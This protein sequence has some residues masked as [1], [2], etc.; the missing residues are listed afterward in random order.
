MRKISSV[1]L[2]LLWVIPAMAQQSLDKVLREVEKNNLAYKA[3]RS[4]VNAQKAGNHVGNTP[5]NP[6]VDGG[7]LWGSPSAIGN[8]KDISVNQEIDFP[9]VY[10]HQNKLADLRDFQADVNAGQYRLALNQE[11]AQLWVELV[12]LNQ[13]IAIQ[14]ERAALAKKLDNAYAERLIAGEANLIDRNKAA[15]NFIQSKK[16][17][18]RLQQEKELLQLSL[19]A[20]NGNQPLPVGQVNYEQINLPPDFELWAQGVMQ[21]NPQARWYTLEAEAADRAVKLNRSKSLPKINGGYMMENTVGEKFQGVTLGLSIPL[22]ENRNQVKAARLRQESNQLEEQDFQS[23][24]KTELLK[25]YRSVQLA[26]ARVDGFRKEL[27]T[28]QQRDLLQ[29]ALD[30]G[31]I[32]LIEY[33]LE[34]QFNYEAIDQLVEA[35]KELQLA[36]VKM[37]VLGEGH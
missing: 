6:Y 19:D 20:L 16:D 22:W 31:Q 12:N 1:L 26:S 23:Q 10:H 24:L 36:W 3:Q 5:N 9:T 14:Q 29:E 2:M 34:M 37:K 11:A 8:R 27:E 7:Y 13:R 35:E 4:S 30:A 32:S 18:A 25:L 17:L 28:V 21:N 33:L 15:L